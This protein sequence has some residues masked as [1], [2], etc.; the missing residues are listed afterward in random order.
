MSAPIPESW[1]RPV[2]PPP[3]P[4]VPSRRNAPPPPSR[5]SPVGDVIASLVA[6]ARATAKAQT[7]LDAALAELDRLHS[8][9]G[10]MELLDEHWP[11][12]IFPTLPDDECRD[13]GPRIVSL[14]RWVQ[15]LREGTVSGT[16]GPKQTRG[17]SPDSGP[18]VTPL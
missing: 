3:N 18:L 2:S 10:L 11:E 13:T 15:A 7:A 9:D 1:L 17:G 4:G 14:L 16:K 12:H 8:W 5:P 6:S